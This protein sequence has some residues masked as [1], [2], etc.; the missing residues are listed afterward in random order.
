MLPQRC[1]LLSNQKLHGGSE[2]KTV[3]MWKKEVVVYFMVLFQDFIGR[4]R[5]IMLVSIKIT[6]SIEHRNP[7]YE[8]SPLSPQK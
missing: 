4:P 8:A 6:S 3:K 5:K 2:G 1:G 7:E